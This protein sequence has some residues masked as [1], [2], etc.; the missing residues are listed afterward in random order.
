M[1][2]WIAAVVFIFVLLFIMMRVYAG[3]G[4]INSS[5]PNGSSIGV[6]AGRLSPC[7]ESDN[8]V[9][10]QSFPEDKLH[11]AEVIKYSEYLEQPMEHLNVIITTMP[12]CKV[13]EQSKLYLR[14]ECTSKL[15][16]F[17]DDLEL[18]IS[19]ENHSIDFR[20][21]SRVGQSDFGVNRKRIEEIRIQMAKL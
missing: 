15:L 12:G 6:E 20:S 3:T 4:K 19:P 5:F 18:L 21:A 13:T 2:K 11:Y 8:C 14:A 7:K 9:S 1:I 17:K 16:K 10:S